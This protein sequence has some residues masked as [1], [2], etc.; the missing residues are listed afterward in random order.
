MLG[1]GLSTA[2]P[3]LLP[4]AAE[5]SQ[6]LGLSPGWVAL[7]AVAA[8]VG[9]AWW[10]PGAP[11][12]RAR[13]AQSFE[14]WDGPLGLPQLATR[15]LA[16]AVLVLG[17]AAGRLGS[18]L[19][20]ENLASALVVGAAW[21][22]L[23]FVSGAGGPVWRWLDPWDGLARMGRSDEGRPADEVWPATVPALVWAW[24]LSVFQQSLSPRAVGLALGAYSLATVAGA[25]AVGR[26]RWFS[27]AEVFGLLFGWLS[28]LPR[29][30]LSGWRPPA[31][32]E[33]VLGTVAGGLLF[34]L[35]RLSEVWGELNVVPGATAYATL[36]LL[37]S[38]GVLAGG[39][40]LLE[41]WAARR[42]AAGSVVAAAVPAVG[43]V[44][45]AVA[46]SRSRVFTAVTLLPSLISD[47]FGRDWDLFG[48]ADVPFQAP[49]GP[50]RL[51]LLQLAV[52]AAGHL[53]GA[54]VLSRRAPDTRAPAALAL[55]MVMAAGCVSVLLAP[56]V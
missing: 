47:P 6:G 23:V 39:L 34:G 12:E 53:A 15:G 27:S 10:W 16:L 22:V 21:P 9:A 44:V 18:P 14:S 5:G 40:W 35:V 42:G 31:G 29:G 30:A 17:V 11:P 46:M 4:E 49:L 56:G 2:W 13:R 43:A 32:A 33:V 36:A 50:V 25:L 19:E 41:R 8:V 26:V 37:G 1:S 54:V 45:L 52:L 51:A 55:G 20:L 7:I 38:A 24:Y 28:R 48:T 3:T